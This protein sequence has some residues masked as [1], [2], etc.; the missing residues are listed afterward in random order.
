MEPLDGGVSVFVHVPF[1]VSRPIQALSMAFLATQEDWS[2]VKFSSR[3]ECNYGFAVPHYGFHLV[4]REY[5][6]TPLPSDISGGPKQLAPNKQYY[7]LQERHFSYSPCR[8]TDYEELD[9]KELRVKLTTLHAEDVLNKG[10][11]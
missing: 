3:P 7:L 11:E 4:E 10:G 5:S 9:P 2:S 6:E 8:I 1:T